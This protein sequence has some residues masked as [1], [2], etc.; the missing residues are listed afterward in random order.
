MQGIDKT[1]DRLVREQLE[2]TRARA[3]RSRARSAARARTCTTRA[4]IS[5]IDITRQ[6]LEGDVPAERADGRREPEASSR[7]RRGPRGPADAD[8]LRRLV[9]HRAR[10]RRPVRH[11]EPQL[12]R[13]G[14]GDRLADALRRAAPRRARHADAAVATLLAA[15]DDREPSTTARSAIQRPKSPTGSTSIARASRLSRSA[16]SPTTTCGAT[17]TATSGRERS[18]PRFPASTKPSRCRR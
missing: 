7:Q 5:V 2:L 17:A 1:S 11:L 6:N 4:R 10:R 3:A 16:S 9:R 12:A 15:R 13:Q 14:P 18:T 8:Q